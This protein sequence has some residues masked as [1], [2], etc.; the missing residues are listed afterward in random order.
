MTPLACHCRDLRR[1]LLDRQPGHRRDGVVGQVRVA[2]EQFQ[3]LPHAPTL[4]DG[5]GRAAGPGDLRGNGWSRTGDNPQGMG[6]GGGAAPTVGW[7][8]DIPAVSGQRRAAAARRRTALRPP[9]LSAR[10]LPRRHPVPRRPVS[11]WPES[12]R[13]STRR[14]STPAGQQYAGGQY[15]PGA[16]AGGQP[17][18]PG[19]SPYAVA[20]PLVATSFSDWW[21]KVIG[22][23]Q[24]K[25]EAAAVHTARYIRARYHH[26]RPGDGVAAVAIGT[27]S[28]AFSIVAALVGLIGALVLIVVMFLAQGVSVF[29]VAKEA[30]GE[31]VDFG[32][33]IRLAAQRA[34]PLLGW[35]LLAG[36]LVVLGFISDPARPLPVDR[37]R[38]LADRGGHLRAG[39]DRS[40]LL[41]R[42]PGVRADAR[43][44]SVLRACRH[45]L[46]GDRRLRSS[47][48]WS[49]AK[50]SSYQLLSNIL[51]LPV[52]F[53][54]VGV[55]IV[56]YATLRNR[57]N[58]AVTTPTLAA[59]LDRP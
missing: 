17:P 57:E 11:R 52:S 7:H 43:A 53:A 34:L 59:E 26:R 20:D 36:I 35:S 46:L 55:G 47:R 22:V 24:P 28:T 49:D 38:C 48:R 4:C 5:C 32:S 56:T 27:E 33:A 1:D 40:Y 19:S 6:S 58:P 54:F 44:P 16:Y 12:R 23:L 9:H 21:A 13:T 8:V 50:D 30:T 39:G 14:G 31:Q 2:L 42:Q 51:S 10:P 37:L 45:C 41:A 18:F 29:V 3:D 15:P 25:L